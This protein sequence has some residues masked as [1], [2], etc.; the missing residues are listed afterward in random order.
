MR[1]ER[2]S[3]QSLAVILARVTDL[4]EEGSA[5]RAQRA[6]ALYCLAHQPEGRAFQKDAEIIFLLRAL[7]PRI[8]QYPVHAQREAQP[9]LKRSGEPLAKMI[10]LPRTHQDFL[11]QVRLPTRLT[12]MILPSDPELEA[13]LSLFE[14]VA[15]HKEPLSALGE[16]MPAGA[17]EQSVARLQSEIASAIHLGPEDATRAQ[18]DFLTRL[19]WTLLAMQSTS[20]ALHAFRVSGLA[21]SI[22]E[23][24]GMGSDQQEILARAG[25]LHDIG[26]LGLPEALLSKSGYLSEAEREDLRSHAALGE[27]LLAGI[28]SLVETA[29]IVGQHHEKCDSSGYPLGLSAAEIDPLARALTVA[30]VYDAL[31]RNRPYRAALPEA[32][33]LA[34]MKGDMAAA[35]DAVSI[36]A[37]E[38]VLARM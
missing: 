4:L 8:N 30:D 23:A 22:G 24:L 38:A 36:E 16:V 3:A 35:L 28:P 32:D 12:D 27:T 9:R 18:A 2:A 31:A 1:V 7:L 21:T 33:A 29:K 13:A 15:R 34:I 26:K 25:L 37:L 17:S 6:A 14:A 20:T 11:H 5:G 19:L 10:A